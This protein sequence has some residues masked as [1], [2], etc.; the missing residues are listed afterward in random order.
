MVPNNAANAKHVND[1]TIIGCRTEA[2]LVHTILKTSFVKSHNDRKEC[3]V[4]LMYDIMKD[5]IPQHKE[6]TPRPAIRRLPLNRSNSN[7][8]RVV[9]DPK[10]NSIETKKLHRVYKNSNG[11]Y[12]LRK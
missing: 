2:A 7:S 9:V 8:S 10:N 6:T 11:M 5:C 4:V 1:A 12:V 3:C